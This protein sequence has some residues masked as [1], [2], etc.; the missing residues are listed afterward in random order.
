MNPLTYTTSTHQAIKRG[1]GHHVTHHQSAATA[2]GHPLDTRPHTHTHTQT[3][4]SAPTTPRRPIGTVTSARVGEGGK[5]SAAQGQKGLL[6]PPPATASCAVREF[7]FNGS[8]EEEDRE[9]LRQLGSMSS[10]WSAEEAG[11]AAGK[12]EHDP[13]LEF[14]QSIGNLRGAR[15]LR[16]RPDSPTLKG[17]FSEYTSL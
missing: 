17:L 14:Q 15:E 2:V 4:Q 10:W 13:W 16:P 7:E 11:D 3:A 1:R 6:P 8:R 9:S 5:H 12:Q